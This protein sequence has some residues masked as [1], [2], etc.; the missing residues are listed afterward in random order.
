MKKFIFTKQWIGFAFLLLL[1]ANPLYLWV[2][3]PFEIDDP[4]PT[5]Y[6]HWEIYL[7]ATA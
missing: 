6:K 3:P 7:G 5:D 4:E 1:A 2:G